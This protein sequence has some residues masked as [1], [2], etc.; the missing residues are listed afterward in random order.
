LVIFREV[1]NPEDSMMA[2]FWNVEILVDTHQD[3][4]ETFCF[5]DQTKEA[6]AGT[7]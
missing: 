2:F 3:F 7:A 6:A 5:H 1:Y 4:R